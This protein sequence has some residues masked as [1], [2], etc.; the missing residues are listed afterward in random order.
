MSTVE[1]CSV[2]GRTILKGERI[3]TYVTP[4]GDRRGV[5]ELCRGRADA[6]GWVWEEVAG[7]PAVSPQ[8][9]RRRRGS[10][11]G[12]LRGRG[13][14][15]DRDEE[16]TGPVPEGGEEGG[17][18]QPPPPRHQRSR[19]P[20][21]PGAQVGRPAAEAQGSRQERAVARFNRSQHARTVAGLIK[22]LGPPSV[23]VG[24]GAGS[25][26]EVRITVAWELSWYQWGVDLQDEER[27]VH[28]IDKGH[29]ITELDGSAR[30]WNAHAAD[31]GSLRLGSAP[32][33][34]GEPAGAES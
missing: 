1:S 19:D 18:Q 12:L 33:G 4:E 11:A 25:P 2:C 16:Q 15:R 13:A 10:L 6:A 7:E 21:A 34:R 22:A 8:R 26:G 27:P 20:A 32:V 28:E 3:R 23:S 30:E 5:C 14:Q 17:A 31:D 29:E 9:Q 24:S